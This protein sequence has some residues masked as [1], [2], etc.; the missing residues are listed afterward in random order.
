MK[1][2]IVMSYVYS[3]KEAY[4]ALRT[5]EILGI[6]KEL[7]IRDSTCPFVVETLGSSSS[8]SW[9]MFYALGVNRLLKCEI[10][11]EVYAVTLC[12]CTD[13]FNTV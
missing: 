10:N 11:E 8:N 2:T 12:F 1:V 7:Y 5:F 3:L 4:E 6:G 9:D 13:K